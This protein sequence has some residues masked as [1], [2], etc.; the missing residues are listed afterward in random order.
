M[1]F[2]E[3]EMTAAVEAVA[4]QLYV[5]TRPPWRRAGAGAAWRGLKPM[6]R[7]RRKAAAGEMVLPALL[8]LPD[9]PTVGSRPE[10]TAAEY[11]EAAAAGT[12]ELLERR[13]PGSW[14]ALPERRRRRLVRTTAALTRAGALAM[15]VR[16]DPDALVVPD[17][18]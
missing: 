17:S 8:A 15:P 3:A 13:S 7:Y 9:R 12:R 11:E 14:D 18:L 4:R 10:F 5:A 6:E 16:Q 1:R 2:T